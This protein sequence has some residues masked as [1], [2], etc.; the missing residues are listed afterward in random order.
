MI[1][2]I[3]QKPLTTEIFLRAFDVWFKNKRI[4]AYRLV[5]LGDFATET[6]PEGADDLTARA[7]NREMIHVDAN[8]QI[9]T[10]SEAYRAGDLTRGYEGVNQLAAT[11]GRRIPKGTQEFDALAVWFMEAEGVLQEA[12]IRWANGDVHFMPSPPP[13]RRKPMSR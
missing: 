2:K 6:L 13:L 1:E 8:Y 4:D 9:H 3:Y 12:R 11:L 7:H 5:S 10:L